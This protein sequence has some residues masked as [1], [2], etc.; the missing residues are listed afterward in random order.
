MRV[1]ECSDQILLTWP[2]G[3]DEHPFGRSDSQRRSSP[4]YFGRWGVVKSYSSARLGARVDVVLLPEQDQEHR[5]REREQGEDQVHE[6]GAV[7][8]PDLASFEQRLDSLRAVVRQEEAADGSAQQLGEGVGVPRHAHVGAFLAFGSDG[9]DVGLELRAP[10]EFAHR[11]DHDLHAHHREVDITDGA[12]AEELAEPQRRDRED[13]AGSSAD[14]HAD[15]Q[16]PV[17]AEALEQ[18]REHEQADDDDDRVERLQHPQVHVRRDH[19][20]VVLGI[21]HEDRDEGNVSRD[22]EEQEGE[23]LAK[24]LVRPDLLDHLAER[25]LLG[26]G[27]DDLRL[28]HGR[29]ELGELR[30]L[31][32]EEVHDQPADDEQ[33]DE[34]P[35]DVGVAPTITKGS[36]LFGGGLVLKRPTH[37]VDDEG[38]HS[39]D[40]HSQVPHVEAR[41]ARLGIGESLHS[42]RDNRGHETVPDHS[43]E[44]E[45]HHQSTSEVV[46][47]EHERRE[48]DAEHADGDDHGGHERRLPKTETVH[49]RTHQ[50]LDD[51]RAE[52]EH[53]EEQAGT[54]IAEADILAQVQRADRHEREVERA[55]HEVQGL[56]GPEL[57]RQLEQL[58][59]VL[60]VGLHRG[61]QHRTPSLRRLIWFAQDHPATQET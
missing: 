24:R 31:L 13:Q 29:V 34:V 58:A 61:Q 6:L 21:D 23:D 53:A 45:E 1:V 43:H 15:G 41:A 2:G 25:R 50:D 12:D 47:A 14:E 52:H 55:I 46:G 32:E 28:R 38:Q 19:P 22:G 5:A 54:F 36:E 42:C 26:L 40:I 27:R 56:D 17:H 57:P 39:S 20:R 9:A 7:G 16:N 10:D 11:E 33:A 51:R 30:L 48:A 4:P 37:E 35:H 60:E 59:E 18:R 8:V 3:Q 49:D 44:V